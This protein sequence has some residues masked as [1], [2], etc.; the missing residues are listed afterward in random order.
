MNVYDEISDL[1]SFEEFLIYSGYEYAPQKGENC[2]INKQYEELIFLNYDSKTCKYT[3]YSLKNQDKGHLIDFVRNRL[4]NYYLSTRDKHD[5]KQALHILKAYINMPED[6]KIHAIKRN[7]PKLDSKKITTEKLNSYQ[8]FSNFYKLTPLH[9]TTLFNLKGINSETLHSPILKHSLY[10]CNAVFFK[11]N[12]H[13]V[14][15]ENGINVAFLYHDIEATEVGMQT[16]YID[17]NQKVKKLFVKDSSRNSAVWITKHLKNK[18]KNLFITEKGMEGVSHHELMNLDLSYRY[19]STG[20]FITE[21]QIQIIHALVDKYRYHI[22]LGNA[23]DKEGQRYNLDIIC[24]LGYTHF[25]TI[26]S[27]LNKDFIRLELQFHSFHDIDQRVSDILNLINK[28]NKNLA[29]EFSPTQLKKESFTVAK[30]S[31]HSYTINIPN[32]AYQLAELN[33]IL[34]NTFKLNISLKIPKSLKNW[35]QDLQHAK[36]NATYKDQ[37][38]TQKKRIK[39]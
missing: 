24:A 17:K 38:I 5:E 6:K 39:L 2:F 16:Y 25:S 1:I 35:N 34:I 4:H 11:E 27:S 10:N 21:N 7:I 32:R 28:V 18:T 13:T 22:A 29:K 23:Y 33:H 20:G 26:K 14:V 31:T 19:L 37:I 15:N 12:G 3:Y 9:D 30:N 8:Y 36:K